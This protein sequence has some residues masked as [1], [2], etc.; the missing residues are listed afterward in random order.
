MP[1]SPKPRRT[2]SNPAKKV[3]EAASYDLRNKYGDDYGGVYRRAGEQL[4]SE[5]N[6]PLTLEVDGIGAGGEMNLRGIIAMGDRES[7][8]LVDTVQHPSMVTAAAQLDRLRLADEAK[9]L[10]IALDAA[11]TIA[12]Q[13]S[14]EKMLAHQ[15]SAAHVLAMRMAGKAG[16]W[17]YEAN[18]NPRNNAD[19]ARSQAAMVEATRA[20]N[21]SA[22]LMQAFQ[23]GMLTLQRIRSGGQQRVTVVHQHVQVAGGQVAVAGAVTQGGGDG[24]GE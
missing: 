24:G 20:A 4:L 19:A 6:A 5:A 21:A 11:D 7:A 9:A 13:N 18:I 2:S 14:M 1:E 16:D 8:L 22:K 23:Q 17:L 10:D 12:P 15:L 3:L